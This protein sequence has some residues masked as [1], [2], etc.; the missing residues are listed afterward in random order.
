MKKSKLLYTSILFFA[1]LWCALIIAAPILSA[2][3]MTTSS[4]II[5]YFFSKVCHQS[6]ER[7]FMICDKQFAVCARCT[8]IYTG[9][10]LGVLIFPIIKV[11]K[12]NFQISR[13]FFLIMI[14]PLLID[15]L[16]SFSGFW[17]NTYLSRYITGLISGSFTALLIVP[18][19]Y[20]FYEKME[21]KHE[22]KT[23]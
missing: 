20:H 7:S 19:C 13:K 3:Q 16:I 4:G 9:F 6:P 23:G 15:V 2:H 14:I 22:F 10:L 8:G 18:G 1:L 5:Y 12:K 17:Q 11:F 21:E